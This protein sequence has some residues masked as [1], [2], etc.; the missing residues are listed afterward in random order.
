MARFASF[1]EFYPFYL[2]EYQNRTCRRLHFVGTSFAIGFIVLF[3]AAH[4]AAIVLAGQFFFTIFIFG[5]GFA[6]AVIP[7][8]AQAYGRGDVVAVRRSVRMG[9]WVVLLYS[10]VTVPIFSRSAP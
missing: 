9:M 4:L 5:S 6:T 2:G 7:M 3:G 1:R 8:V 10:L